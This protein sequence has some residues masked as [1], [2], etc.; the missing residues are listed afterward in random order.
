MCEAFVF[1]SELLS[2]SGAHIPYCCCVRPFRR[3]SPLTPV[4]CRAGPIWHADFAVPVPTK[5]LTEGG[6]R[7][8][9]RPWA[10]DTVRRPSRV[11]PRA[12]RLLPGRRVLAMPAGHHARRRGPRIDCRNRCVL[13][14]PTSR[15]PAAMPMLAAGRCCVPPC[16][17][18][19]ATRCLP[20]DMGG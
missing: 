16:L 15:R 14:L 1:A 3:H 4:S 10:G 18:V 8:C 17:L 20:V 13:M 2:S 7:A 19:V 6:R 9:R 5:A 12:S 11:A